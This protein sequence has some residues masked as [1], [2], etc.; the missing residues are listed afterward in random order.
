M[1]DARSGPMN[2]PNPNPQDVMIE[3]I[4]SQPADSS[5]E[6]LLHELAMHRMI[7]R[8]LADSDADRVISSEAMKRKIDSWRK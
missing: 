3:I 4:K 6:D 2:Q 5:F 7:R 8:G 1:S